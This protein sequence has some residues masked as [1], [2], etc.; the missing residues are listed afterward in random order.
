[1]VLRDPSKGRFT[2]RSFLAGPL[3]VVVV[4]GVSMGGLVASYNFNQS[5]KGGINLAIT[6]FDL[7]GDLGQMGI[8][9]GTEQSNRSVDGHDDLVSSLASARQEIGSMRSS[10]HAPPLLLRT[11]NVAT[12]YLDFV[13][14]SLAPAGTKVSAVSIDDVDHLLDQAA[15][16]V[17]QS[18]LRA[19][20]NATLG[21]VATLFGVVLFVV[22]GL[23]VR[24]RERS[25]RRTAASDSEDAIRAQFEAMVEHSTDLLFLTDESTQIQYCSPSAVALLGLTADETRSL[26]LGSLIHPDDIVVASAAFAAVT[27]NGKADP[28][29][30]RLRH[31]DGGWRTL[32]FT[33]NDLSKIST[34]QAMAWHARDVTDRRVLEEQ[35]S[36]QAFEDPL[37]GLAN[38]ALLGDRLSHVL[39]RVVR[40]NRS[41]AVLMIDL[42]AFKTI[43]DGMGHNVGDAAIKEIGARISQS[44]RPGDTVARMGGDE[45]VVLLEDLDDVMVAE[46]IAD[47]ILE[48]IRQPIAINETN[49]LISASIGIVF[50]RAADV[51]QESLLSDADVAMY[52]SKANGRDRW[53]RFEPAMGVRAAQELR[54]SQDLAHALER[55]ELVVFYQPCVDLK[56][57]RP[58]GVEALLR[59][60]HPVV[61]LV[62]P[63]IFIPIAEQNALIVPIGRWVLEQSCQQAIAWQTEFPNHELSMSVNVSGR[64][65]NDRSLV[66]DVRSILRNSGLDPSHLTLEVTESVL[67]SDVHLIIERLG[68]LKDLGI[69]IAIDDFGTG[70]SSLGYLRQLPIDI[71]K[72]DKT[73]VDAASAGDPGGEAII[74][75]IL[76]LS[77]GM[78]LK[79]VAEGIEDADQALLLETLGCHSAQGYLFSRPLPPEELRP[80][81]SATTWGASVLSAAR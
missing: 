2:L 7:R 18:A 15:T 20:S 34:V 33:A 40:T 67:M 68:K 27:T 74:R 45:F 49:L 44:A 8:D 47:R 31:K 46:D 58:E 12:K 73:F 32:E 75:A 13:Q 14:G 17:Q 1:M 10:G 48:L 6:A 78:H 41:V 62:A 35:L 3:L 22:V 54:L 57:W 51:T 52:T 80:F 24:E 39:A 25:R 43:N 11:L 28:F 9:L 23:L 37:T 21:T 61:G 60:K 79:T 59:W 77:E 4:V 71:L 76:H 19:N 69:S 29:D 50:S 5:A 16:E 64:Q 56:T 53:T 63:D 38:R 81:F 26:D 72:I 42:D 66:P 65:L 70:Y 36:R 55:E 30:L